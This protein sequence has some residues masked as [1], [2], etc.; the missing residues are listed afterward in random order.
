MLARRAP[1]GAKP[2]PAP[3]PRAA[4]PDRPPAAAD[5]SPPA[6]R[7][8]GSCQLPPALTQAQPP[9]IRSQSSGPQ[10]ATLSPDFP[11]GSRDT[12]SRQSTRHP[13]KRR[14]P[15]DSALPVPPIAR[16]SDVAFALGPITKRAPVPTQAPSTASR[17]PLFLLLPIEPALDLATT[18][19]PRSKP[20]HRPRDAPLQCQASVPLAAGPPTAA[21]PPR[22]PTPRT[23]NRPKRPP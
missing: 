16:S 11:C 14:H 22:L 21:R 10:R 23:L 3:T 1:V 18:L 2:L 13:Q 20:S 9:S 5:F 19:P 4:V 12:I 8:P 6:A 17:R 15:H 7:R